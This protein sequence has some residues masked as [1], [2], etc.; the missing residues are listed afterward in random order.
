MLKDLE[1]HKIVCAKCGVPWPCEAK[2]AEILMKIKAEA[3]K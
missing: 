3:K 1:R 2:Q